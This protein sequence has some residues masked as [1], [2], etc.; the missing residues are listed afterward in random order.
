MKELERPTPSASRRARRPGSLLRGP[1][2]EGAKGPAGS[3]LPG[4]EP[5]LAV[6]ERVEDL[7]R[8]ERTMVIAR[9]VAL[10]WTLVQVLVYPLPY[11]PGLKQVG[12]GLVAL[13][14]VANLGA[15]YCYPRIRTVQQA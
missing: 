14:A 13:L 6:A 8:S 11:P 3:R 9:A 10:P 7:R 15:W 1:M 5:A 2:P 12:L 4:P